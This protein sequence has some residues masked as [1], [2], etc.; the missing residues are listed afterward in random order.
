MTY[1]EALAQKIKFGETYSEDNVDYKVIIAP[2]QISD[3]EKFVGEYP[4][5]SYSDDTAIAFSSN[6][7]FRICGLW[8]DGASIISKSYLRA[9]YDYNSLKSFI[10]CCIEE[11][12][13]I[14][15]LVNDIKRD[16][17]IPWEDSEDAILNHIDFM[18]ATRHNKKVFQLFK[19]AYLR[20]R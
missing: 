19:K 18:T 7:K 11:E 1:Q 8:T 6:E 13:P 2:N 3:F 9:A 12:S 10:D 15:D 20:H 4:S 16:N 5:M 17:E 14:G